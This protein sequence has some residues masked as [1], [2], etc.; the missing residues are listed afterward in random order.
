MGRRRD[1]L[2]GGVDQ[3]AIDTVRAHGGDVVVTFGGS[4]GPFLE[5]AC[6]TPAALAGAY[7]AVIDAYALKAIDIDVESPSVLKQ[8]R[9]SRAGRRCAEDRPG[10]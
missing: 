1:A 8:R 7:Q 4:E 3:A 9:S 6:E 10:Q 5:D 2:T